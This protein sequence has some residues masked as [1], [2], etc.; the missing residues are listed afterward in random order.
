MKQTTTTTTKPEIPTDVK[1]AMKIF[2]LLRKYVG[3]YGDYRLR[4]IQRGLLRSR[5]IKSNWTYPRPNS[6]IVSFKHVRPVQIRY[7]SRIGIGGA[8]RSALSTISA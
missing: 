3:P 6:D 5:G 7:M 8:R 1:S 4:H 2:R